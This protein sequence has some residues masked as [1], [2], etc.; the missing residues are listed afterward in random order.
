MQ[1]GLFRQ[2]H[3]TNAEERAKLE[4][5]QVQLMLAG[6]QKEAE[7]LAKLNIT[8]LAEYQKYQAKMAEIKNAGMQA[9][10]AKELDAVR[11]KANQERTEMTKIYGDQ[12]NIRLALAQKEAQEEY[13]VRIAMMNAEMAYALM[14]SKEQEKYDADRAEF[15]SRVANM[16]FE[17]FKRSDDALKE[18]AKTPGGQKALEEQTIEWAKQGKAIDD[19]IIEQKV[20]NATIAEVA[21]LYQNNRKMGKEWLEEEAAAIRDRKREELTGGGTGLKFFTTAEKAI[22]V[23]LKTTSNVNVTIS[24]PGE[25]GTKVADEVVKVVKPLFDDVAKKTA[26]DVKTHNVGAGV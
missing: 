13:A 22:D 15:K 19:A 24:N 11:T 1:E 20:Y 5:E 26:N 10:L 16:S 14:S 4:K 12:M 7:G 25:L 6:Q 2:Q 23:S 8:T 18:L 9:G 21:Q 17:E 3:R